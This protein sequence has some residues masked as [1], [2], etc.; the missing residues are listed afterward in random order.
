MSRVSARGQPSW[1]ESDSPFGD[2]SRGFG[3]HQA[4]TADR[5]ATEMHEVPA[6]CKAVL[7]EILA[8]RRNAHSILQG[9]IDEV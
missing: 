6:V 2:N 8:H 4:C 9:H 5:A 7:T 3:Q 1:P